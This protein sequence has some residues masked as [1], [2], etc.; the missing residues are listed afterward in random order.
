MPVFKTRLCWCSDCPSSTLYDEH[1]LVLGV[2]HVEAGREDGEVLVHV[3][4]VGPRRPLHVQ[5]LRETGAAVAVV[6]PQ[7]PP[8]R[9]DCLLGPIHD[10]HA[11]GAQLIAALAQAAVAVLSGAHDDVAEAVA[12]VEAVLA[13]VRTSEASCPSFS[14]T[15]C[16]T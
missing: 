13:C 15:T 6:A 10:A 9:D 7:G 16:L 14:S 8:H 2:E 11:K 4:D 1:L 5:P 12:H 3:A